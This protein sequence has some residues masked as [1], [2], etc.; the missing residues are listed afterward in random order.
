M[1]GRRIITLP[2]AD[3]FCLVTN[4]KRSHQRLLKEIDH[5]IKSMGLRLKPSKCRS[6]SLS[7]G[8]FADID[9]VI[10]EDR[11]YSIGSDIHKY[12]GAVLTKNLTSGDIHEYL[13]KKIENSLT[14]IDKSLVRHEYKLKV[15]TRYLLP[16]LRFD[17]TVNDMTQSHCKSLDALTNRF[18]KKWCGLPRPGTIAFVHMPNGLDIPSISD[19]YAECHTLSYISMRENGDDLVN[20]VLDS[21]LDRESKWVR[22]KSSIVSCDE[23][24]S[25]VKEKEPTLKGKK[26]EAK[27]ILSQEVSTIWHSHV[28]EL[29]VQGKFL[30]LLSLES[31]C[32]IWKSIMYNLPVKV[33]KFLVNSVSDT[34]NTRANLLRW[35]QS[36]T[37]KCKHCCCVETLCH[38]LN[39]C[40]VFLSQGRYTWRHNNVL[41]CFVEVAAQSISPDKKIF[42]DIPSLIGY[43]PVTTIPL[44]CTQTELRPDFCLYDEK[45]K[46]IVIMELSVPFELGIDKAHKYKVDKYSALITDI[47]NNGFQVEF[48]AIEIGSRGFVSSENTRSLKRF[49]QCMDNQNTKPREFRNMLSRMALVSSFAVYC[50]KDEASWQDCETLSSL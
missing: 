42:H 15:Y 21:Q 41:R 25:S 23:V 3:D 8:K 31:T 24:Y 48:L 12:L 43:S 36:T 17:L 37:N 40:S 32:T 30:D 39:S 13:S 29:I 7:S 47:K 46:T 18:L 11:I 35:G 5:R 1:D 33:L 50:A 6:L 27:K 22:K 4:N 10:G 26:K 38:V 34:V 19:L 28:K 49:L 45:K 2:F 16:S 20:H 14:N 44:A 9:Y